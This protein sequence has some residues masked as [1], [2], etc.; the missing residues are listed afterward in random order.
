VSIRPPIAIVSALDAGIIPATIRHPWNR[1]LCE[2]ED[3]ICAADW[4]ELE[5]RLAPVLRGDRRAV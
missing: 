5:R 2:E 1:E 3:V 4:P